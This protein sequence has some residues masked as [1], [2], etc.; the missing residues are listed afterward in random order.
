MKKIF[1][2]VLV[3]VMVL[4]LCACGDKDENKPVSPFDNFISGENGQ[5]GN[6]QPSSP[7]PSAVVLPQIRPEDE[8]LRGTWINSTSMN[9]SDTLDHFYGSDKNYMTF[10]ANGTG[11]LVL[12]GDYRDLTWTRDE[13]SFTVSFPATG[14]VFSGSIINEII[15]ELNAID[16]GSEVEYTFIKIV[17]G[18]KG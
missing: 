10:S 12:G 1:L 9:V 5:E 2:A 7:E 3:L 18:K 17:E 8:Y 15:Y 16:N 4:A 6:G 14:E 13:N 11:S